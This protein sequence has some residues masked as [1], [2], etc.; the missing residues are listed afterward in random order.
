MSSTRQNV[1][2]IH[3]LSTRRETATQQNVRN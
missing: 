1:R 3:N 2:E